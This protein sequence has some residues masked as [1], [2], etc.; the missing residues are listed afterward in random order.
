MI[1]NYIIFS[2]IFLNIGIIFAL[3]VF[4]NYATSKV[5]TFAF[6]C[7]MPRRAPVV[8]IRRPDYRV[9]YVA[10]VCSDGVWDC[11]HNGSLWVHT[12][13]VINIPPG[14]GNINTTIQ[15]PYGGVVP[16]TISLFGLLLKVENC[17]LNS[18]VRPVF[19]PYLSVFA[20]LTYPP[21]SVVVKNI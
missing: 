16:V 10:V 6:N 12:S 3:S 11:V 20:I 13:A 14:S 9:K 17:W 4:E 18:G 7:C 5:F 19:V 1:P 21:I 8:K 2:P 15:T